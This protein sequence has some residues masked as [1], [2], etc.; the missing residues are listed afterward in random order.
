M[1]IQCQTCQAYLCGCTVNPS[2]MVYCVNIIYTWLLSIWP[3]KL[4]SKRTLLAIT[5]SR[6]YEKLQFQFS[7][8]FQYLHRHMTI[9]STQWWPL[10]VFYW[11]NLTTYGKISHFIT[12][13]IMGWLQLNSQICLQFRSSPNHHDFNDSLHFNNIS[14]VYP[15]WT[16]TCISVTS[17]L[18]FSYIQSTLE[19]GFSM[20]KHPYYK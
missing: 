16:P 10:V 17:P 13:K 2:H 9:L 14:N 5:I 7:H 19:S 15:Q 6:L 1:F 20:P 12:V 18:K 8:G 11:L 4:T 3:I